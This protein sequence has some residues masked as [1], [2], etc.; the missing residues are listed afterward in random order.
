[1][2]IR[3]AL[4]RR[5]QLPR[6][7]DT[8]ASPAPRADSDR[9]ATL[10]ILIV[11][12]IL[13][14]SLRFYRLGADEMSR[15]EAASWTA[16]AAPTVA[17]SFALSQQLNPGK[18]GIYDVALHLW[19]DA[20]GDRVG[21]MRTLSAL[22]GTLT[23]LV[24]FITVREL[25]AALDDADGSLSP[26]LAAAFAALLFACNL[27]MITTDR[28][29]RMYPLMLIATLAQIWFFIRSSRRRGAANVIAAG[30]FTALATACNF[31]VLGF[32]AAEALWLALLWLPSQS[33]KVL[34]RISVTR[35]GAAL[36]LAAAM[37]IPLGIVDVR[38]AL[39]ALHAGVLGTIEPQ[40]PW[41]PVR[42]LM[43]LTGNAA[44]WPL[45]LMALYATWRQRSTHRLGVLF[46]LCWLVIPFGLI[47]IVSYAITPLMVERYVLPSLV[48]FL[49]LA[50]IGIASVRGAA[51]RYAIAILV[52][53]Q[54]L[55][56]LHH[57]WR[58]P[59]DVQWREAA[60]FAVAATPAGRQVAVVPLEP[61]MVLR[62]YLDQPQR[63]R[64]VGARAQLDPASRV[65][66]IACGP[67]P[68]LIADSA[69]PSASLQQISSC[70]PRL[71]KRFRLVEVR[72][73]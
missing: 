68:I 34:G 45:T 44:F 22:L 26:E 61:L 17:G 57:H 23:I 7:A 21:A 71:L 67:E 63:L 54:S 41:W 73:R 4:A 36:I 27:R 53:G 32:F 55:A 40:P 50:A 39:G 58:N 19:I 62:Y 24:L 18:A 38:A 8:S 29:A 46:I 33:R 16:A 37:F 43:V 25:L 47:E 64:L 35:P 14:G 30:F 10:A 60:R 59:E 66:T 48:A 20:V 12:V 5:L 51:L 52:V 28:T 42:A 69:L 72:A 1:M 31:I 2:S 9:R 49:V 70:Y 13:G 3:E 6:L 65:W 11:A 15:G 56:H